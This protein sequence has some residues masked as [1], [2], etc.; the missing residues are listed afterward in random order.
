[1]RRAFSL[2]EVLIVVGLL[3]LVAAV[4]LKGTASKPDTVEVAALA[5]TVAAE[6]RSAAQRARTNGYP[7]ALVIPSEGG[8]RPHSQ[9]LYRVEGAEPRIVDIRD[10]SGD[11]KRSCI[12]AG[13]V[14]PAGSSTVSQPSDGGNG[15][16]FNLVDWV[17]D[18]ALDT[19]YVV[20]FTPSGSVVTNDLPVV[21]GSFKLLVAYG[22]RYSAAGPP[23]GTGWGSPLLLSFGRGGS[24]KNL[25]H[26]A[27]RTSG[28]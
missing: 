9:S 22:I 1:M 19:D 11:F 21:D 3:G 7:V 16:T 12:A 18:S 2:L 24:R 23:S 25:V 13:L 28:S 27:L 5:D 26:F 4:V 10:F 20:C 17:G 14:Y 8:S 6:L 15:S